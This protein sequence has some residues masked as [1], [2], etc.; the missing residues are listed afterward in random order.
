MLKSGQP[1]RS[2]GCV[3]QQKVQRICRCVSR[4]LARVLPGDPRFCKATLGL[5]NHRMPIWLDLSWQWWCP[6]YCMC[7]ILAYVEMSSDVF[8]NTMPLYVANSWA[9]RSKIWQLGPNWDDLR[10]QLGGEKKLID[11]HWWI[12]NSDGWIPKDFTPIKTI[13]VFTVSWMNGFSFQWMFMKMFSHSWKCFHV[14]K[15]VCGY[16]FFTQLVK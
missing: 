6:I 2:V 11:C 9:W 8:L 13:T 5:W 7:L 3:K 4:T 12:V 14:P 16:I 15:K 1:C 10:C